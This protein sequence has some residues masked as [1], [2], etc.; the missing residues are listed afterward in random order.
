MAALSVNGLRETIN[1]VKRLCGQWVNWMSSKIKGEWR[2]HNVIEFDTTSA[3]VALQRDMAC[4]VLH[5]FKD[6]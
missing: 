6:D 3:E 1:V 5:C 4:D 2:L